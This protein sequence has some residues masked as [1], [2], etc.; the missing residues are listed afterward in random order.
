MITLEKDPIVRSRPK[1]VSREIDGQVVDLQMIDFDKRLLTKLLTPTPPAKS[2]TRRWADQ[3]DGITLEDHWLPSSGTSYA[4]TSYVK[5]HSAPLPKWL[6]KCPDPDC[7]E[8]PSIMRDGDNVPVTQEHVP[9]GVRKQLHRIADFKL[10]AAKAGS[11]FLSIALFVDGAMGQPHMIYAGLISTACTYFFMFGIKDKK[12]AN[13]M[14]FPPVEIATIVNPPALDQA[15]STIEQMNRDKAIRQIVNTQ[16][17]YMPSYKKAKTVDHEDQ[18]YN[19][20]SLYNESV[21]AK[22]RM[23]H[24]V[25][26]SKMKQ[27]EAL[28]VL[29]KHQQ[30]LKDLK[31]QVEMDCRKKVN[32]KYHYNDMDGDMVDYY[33]DTSNEDNFS[34]F[35]YSSEAFNK[36]Y[37][38][39][40]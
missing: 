19:E 40:Y 7:D 25:D 9:W 10:L 36:K 32:T 17:K 6:T 23:V 8:R 35:G 34:G 2:I 12:K 28:T 37:S 16:S 31:A 14:S 18:F 33:Q 5:K 13:V 30:D 21:A 15:I 24:Y 27:T 22:D 39:K 38:V 1:T 11:S 29:A 26:V 3:Q 20:S 4:E